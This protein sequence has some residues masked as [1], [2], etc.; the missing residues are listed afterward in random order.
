MANR[1]KGDYTKHSDK[2][3]LLLLKEEVRELEEA[4]ESGNHNN[5]IYECADVANYA[6]F[7]AVKY[8]G[9]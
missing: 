1:E 4:I 3:L 8:K 5:I 2:E 6:R 7:I 9:E